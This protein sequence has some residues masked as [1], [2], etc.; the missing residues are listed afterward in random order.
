MTIKRIFNEK[1]GNNIESIIYERIRRYVFMLF[2]F[3]DVKLVVCTTVDEKEYTDGVYVWLEGVYSALIM[4]IPEYIL[5][6]MVAQEFYN[7]FFE[8]GVREI[9]KKF[10]T[11]EED[12]KKLKSK[13]TETPAMK[14]KTCIQIFFSEKR[15]PFLKRLLG[16]LKCV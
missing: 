15:P 5:I 2:P 10:M 16:G 4:R 3:S 14:S 9:F 12:Y 13:G 7:P 6:K 8:D 1:E 11:N